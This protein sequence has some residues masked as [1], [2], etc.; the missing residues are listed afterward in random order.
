MTASAPVGQTSKSTTDVPAGRL[1][2][3]GDAGEGVTLSSAVVNGEVAEGACANADKARTGRL[4]NIANARFNAWFIKASSDWTQA[5]LEH[6]PPN[7]GKLGILK[8]SSIAHE[9]A[10]RVPRTV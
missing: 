4:R 10:C 9:D 8:S 7:S 3:E 6:A 1:N 5:I 2:S